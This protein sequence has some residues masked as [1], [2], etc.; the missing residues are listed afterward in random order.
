MARQAAIL[1]LDLYSPAFDQLHYPVNFVPIDTQIKVAKFHHSSPYPCSPAGSVVWYSTS[2]RLFIGREST[3]WAKN[4]DSVLS[5]IS[6]YN[7][8]VSDKTLLTAG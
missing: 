3:L 6:P 8:L 2:L 1:R 7:E 5:R 4:I